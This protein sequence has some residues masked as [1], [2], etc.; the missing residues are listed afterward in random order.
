MGKVIVITSGKGGTGKTTISSY[1]GYSMVCRGH[2]TLIVDCDAGLRGSDLLLGISQ[3][4]IF[5]IADAVAGNCQKNDVIYACPN[6]ERLYLVP[7]PL[8]VEDELSPLVLKQFVDMVK[9]DYDYVIIDCP[10]GIGRSFQVAVTP[11]DLCLV[12]VLPEAISVRSGATVHKRLKEL[13]KTD[14]RLI[15][16]RFSKKLFKN[17]IELED[18]DQV[19]D[20]TGLQ[21]IAVLE[22]DKYLLPVVEGATLKPAYKTSFMHGVD[23][24]A[25]RIDGEEVPLGI[26]Y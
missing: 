5:D 9:Q 10:A 6:I 17:Q 23:R 16:N 15:I 22:D 14:T 18:L 24:L 7:A 13:G 12:S 25:A 3:N 21:L 26:K 19:I 20:E 11:A 1:L 2:K 4:L 8:D